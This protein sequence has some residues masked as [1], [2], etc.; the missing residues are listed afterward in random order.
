[1]GSKVKT[2][3]FIGHNIYDTKPKS[4]NRNRTSN[5]RQCHVGWNLEDSYFIIGLLYIKIKFKDNGGKRRCFGN[6]SISHPKII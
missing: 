6:D 3:L 1:M 5:L 2:L 4:P